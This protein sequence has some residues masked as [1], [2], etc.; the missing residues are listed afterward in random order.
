V[1]GW[2]W[3][4]ALATVTALA[5]F[6]GCSAEKGVS[7]EEVV[8]MLPWTVGEEASYSIVDRDGGT[9]G[10][11]VLSIE[12]GDGRL[13]LVQQ[14]QNA[15][16]TDRTILLVEPQTLKP[17][18]GERVISGDKGELNVNVRYLGDS[19]EVQRVA[20]ENGKRE[21][22]IDRLSVPDHAYDTASSLFLWRTI[23]LQEEHQVTYFNLA[24][25]IVGKPQRN[26]LTIRVVGREKV[27][28]P[29]GTF[30]TWRLEI[31]S[32]GVRQTAWY[33]TSDTHP[34]V[35]YDNGE[36]LF[37]LEGVRHV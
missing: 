21:G 10:T 30:Q 22:R 24:T 26:R 4:V 16:F 1:K 5:A 32:S 6:A 15:E 19:V 35:K 8:T 18:S 28:V 37:L 9:L 2:H 17:V 14:Y 27:Q 33:G 29:A 36:T 13:R 23:R 25:A 12:E 11:G 34:L 31:R 3:V 7:T 20:T